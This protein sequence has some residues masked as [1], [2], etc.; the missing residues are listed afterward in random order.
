LNKFSIGSVV[1]DQKE[2]PVDSMTIRDILVRIEEQ[3]LAPKQVR[4]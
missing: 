2:K 1:V 3:C 4:L